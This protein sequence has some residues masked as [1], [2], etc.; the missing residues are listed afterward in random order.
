MFTQHLA[1][2]AAER[3]WNLTSTGA[4]PGY[5]R[6]NLQSTGINLGRDKPTRGLLNRLDFL[7]S[8]DVVPGTEPLLHAAT[9]PDVVAG[10]YYGP[11]GRF[12]L[13]G[14]TVTARPTRRAMDAATNARLWTESERLTGVAFPASAAL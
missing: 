2:V 3:G 11:G 1:V 9:S 13:V 6:T 10:G 8:Q 14:P 12:S 4:H 7:P 5:T